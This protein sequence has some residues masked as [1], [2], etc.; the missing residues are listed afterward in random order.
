MPMEKVREISKLS[1]MSTVKSWL[2]KERED[3]RKRRKER[4]AKGLPE[5]ELPN[6]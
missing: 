3:E 2:R 1:L 5:F 4:K 6:E